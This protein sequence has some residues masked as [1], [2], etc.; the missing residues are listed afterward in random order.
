MLFVL[1]TTSHDRCPYLWV[2]VCKFFVVH[3]LT[4]WSIQQGLHLFQKFGN[5]ATDFSFWKPSVVDVVYIHSLVSHD[6]KLM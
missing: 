4:I 1:F 2:A 5:P 6:T 3:K